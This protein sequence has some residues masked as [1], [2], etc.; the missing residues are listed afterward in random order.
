MMLFNKRSINNDKYLKNLFDSCNHIYFNDTLIPIP[1][2]F[3]DN[4]AVNGYFKFDVDYE[5]K[6]LKNPRIEISSRLKT[7]IAQ[8]KTM[9]H[10]MAHYKQFMD[11][12]S[13]EIN[14][15]FKAYNMGNTDKF[16]K[17][18]SIN[19]YSH[20]ETWKNIIESINN[21]YNLNILIE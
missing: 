12:S 7:F 5:H 4:S 19:E 16:Y 1:V 13:N 17:I 11:L 8:E 3:I 21:K 9:I 10:E 6:L 15:A 2:Y 14:S 18:L 20:N